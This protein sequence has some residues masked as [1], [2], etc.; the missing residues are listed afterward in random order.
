MEI[1]F[2]VHRGIIPHRLILFDPFHI[3]ICIFIGY[4]LF[5]QIISTLI[6]PKINHVV[7]AV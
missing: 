6:Q 4:I 7:L 1:Y 5:Y 2:S 3:A